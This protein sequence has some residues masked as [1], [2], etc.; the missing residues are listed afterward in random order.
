MAELSQLE[1]T[2]LV[3]RTITSCVTSRDPTQLPVG[4][5]HD[6]RTGSAERNKTSLV[7]VGHK[8]NMAAHRALNSG[9]RTDR[10]TQRQPIAI[11]ANS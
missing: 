2:L 11:G 8:V 10:P 4:V 5:F 9:G 1:S 6:R 3:Q 7:R